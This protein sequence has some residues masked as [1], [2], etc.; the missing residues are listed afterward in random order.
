[1]SSPVRTLVDVLARMDS[2]EIRESKARW[3][4]NS[5]AVA[6]QGVDAVSSPWATVLTA[7]DRDAYRAMS[8]QARRAQ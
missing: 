2:P 4:R 8:H 7:N 1:M 6:V 5:R 3:I